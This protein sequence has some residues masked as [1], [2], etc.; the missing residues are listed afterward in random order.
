M[1]VAL[2]LTWKVRSEIKAEL[3]AQKQSLNLPGDV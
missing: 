2:T 1:S 3:V